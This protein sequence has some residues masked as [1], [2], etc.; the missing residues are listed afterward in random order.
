[1]CSRSCWA[2]ALGILR[3]RSSARG[4]EIVLLLLGWG[5]GLR[6]NKIETDSLT[7]AVRFWNRTEA[8]DSLTVAVRLGFGALLSRDRQGAVF[9]GAEAFVHSPIHSRNVW[10]HRT[11][12]CGFRIQWPSSGNSSSLDGIFWSCKAVKSCKPCV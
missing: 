8:T 2:I 4:M 3:C 11:L 1:M 6:W 10:Y 5:R 12:F 9:A 7:V